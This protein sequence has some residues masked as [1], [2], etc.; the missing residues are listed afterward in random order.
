MSEV[1]PSIK[2]DFGIPETIRVIDEILSR[3]EKEGRQGRDL[4]CNN[5]A[6]DAEAASVLVKKLDDIFIELV[7]GFSRKDL[8]EDKDKLGEYVHGTKEYLHRRE[9][10]PKLEETIGRLRAAGNDPGL[11]EKRYRELV[12][13]VRSLATRL[14]FYRQG[15]GRGGMTGVGQ[16]AESN[17]ETI[18]ERVEGRNYGGGNINAS[19]ETMAEEVL[20]NHDFDL[21]DSVHRLV[22]EVRT[23]SRLAAL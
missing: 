11:S 23:R 18:C 22:G 7:S 10:L 15:L 1:V 16:L 3:R 19:I 8:V 17:L 13:S 12:V 5:I 9:L 21:S 20:R 4:L 14:E 6:D 2:I